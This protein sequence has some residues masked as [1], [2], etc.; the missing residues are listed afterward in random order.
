MKKVIS[1][2]LAIMLGAGLISGLAGCSSSQTVTLNISAAASVTDV[3][4]EINKMYQDANPGIKIQANFAS[5]GTLQTQIENGARVDLFIS[6]ASKQM[7]ILENKDLILEDT[8]R[9][10]LNNRVVVIILNESDLEINN[11]SDLANNQIKNIAMG[12]P[13]FV[14]AG[15][16]GKNALDF[17]GIYEQVQPKLILG[18]DVWQVLSYVENGN[19]D[20]GILYSTDANVSSK[21]I[22][23]ADAP[24]QINS[25]IVYPLA[26]IKT[27]QHINEAQAYIDFLFGDDAKNVFEQYGFKVIG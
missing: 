25:Q 19:V 20:A 17:L 6:A 14:P 24:D 26:V 8:R 11:F 2:I 5:S 10:L 22:I 9:D 4:K 3:L 18:S 15:T 12:D 27:S 21:V 7:D 13:E 23:A 16:Y 1:P